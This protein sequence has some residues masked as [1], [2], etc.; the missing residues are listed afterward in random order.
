MIG[1]L[2]FSLLY[3]P[4]NGGISRQKFNVK[5]ERGRSFYG[6]PKPV[7][8]PVCVVYGGGYS[9]F[10]ILQLRVIEEIVQKYRQGSSV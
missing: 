3:Q 4:I 5:T 9:Y 6:P 7:H 1:Y 2:Y 8:K 10:H